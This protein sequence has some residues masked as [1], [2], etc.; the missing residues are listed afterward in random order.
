MLLPQS[1][2]PF[3]TPPGPLAHPTPA[4][5]KAF[6]AA[7]LLIPHPGGNWLDYCSVVSW[8]GTVASAYCSNCPDSSGQHHASGANDKTR[9]YNQLYVF[10]NTTACSGYNPSLAGQGVT[11]TD[12]CGILT[13]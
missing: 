1:T 5:L 2:V 9:V 13:C 3:T 12:D 11:I 6:T 7:P 10:I 8:D 4:Q